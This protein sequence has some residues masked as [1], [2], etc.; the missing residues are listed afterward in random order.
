MRKILIAGLGEVGTAHANL[1]STVKSFEVKG[2]DLDES[3]V[4]EKWRVS[5]ENYQADILVLA[6]RHHP[7]YVKTVSDYIEKY[8]PQIVHVLSTVPPGTC[9]KIGHGAS[10]STTRGVHPHLEEG[11]LNIVKHVGGPS[12]EAMSRIFALAGIRCYTHALAK[13]T[14]V[15]HILN[16]V[17][18]GVNLML[19]DEMQ[20][21]C[22]EFG[23]DYFQAVMG[24][25]ATNNDGYIALDQ[26]SKVR[27]ILTPPNGRI[28]GHCLKQSANLIPPGKRPPMIDSLANYG[29]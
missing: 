29:E 9:A 17:A 3:R 6:M 15:G 11:L 7:E 28:G 4:P 14:E 27:M 2:I 10:H 8:K 26:A 20:K 25:T 13:T 5:D 1:L 19:A 22:R 24:Y 21:V 16:N 18:Y 12:A 23:V